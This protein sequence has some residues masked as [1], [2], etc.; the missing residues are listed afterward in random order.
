[1][2]YLT[3]LLF[4]AIFIAAAA[5]CILLPGLVLLHAFYVDILY[6]YLI[7][8]ITIIGER[9]ILLLIEYST[10]EKNKGIKITDFSFLD[11]QLL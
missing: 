1:M 3:P 10:I 2:K 7:L 5:I 11:S 9:F 6:S 4:S 8:I